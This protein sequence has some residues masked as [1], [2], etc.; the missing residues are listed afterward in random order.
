M[1]VLEYFFLYNIQK[2]TTLFKRDSDMGIWVVG[3]TNQL[4]MK[5][6]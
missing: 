5:G 1:P 4:F 2:T 3:T 6:S